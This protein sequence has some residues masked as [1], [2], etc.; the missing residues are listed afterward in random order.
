MPQ[1]KFRAIVIGGGPIGL[2]I[3]NGLD[4]A[5]IDFLV[6]ERN[7]NIISKSGACIMAWPHTTRIFDQ[8]GLTAACQGRYLPLQSKS[9]AHLDGRPI[10]ANPI[11]EYLN[12]NHGYPCMNFPRPSLTQTLFEGLGTNQAKVRTGAGIEG[13]E[14][15]DNGV[16][17]RLTDGSFEDGSIVIG[18]D[19]VHS[20]TRAIM[21]KLAEEAG[22]DFVKEEDPIVSNYQILYGRAKYVPG[23]KVGQFFET[24]GTHRSSQISAD[25]NRMHFGIYRKLPNPTTEAKEYSE[26]EVA[27]FAEAFSDVMVMPNLSFTELYKNCEWTKLANQQEGVLKHWYYNRIVLAGDSTVQMTAAMGMGLNNGIQSAVFLVNKLQEL[28]SKDS[29]PDTAALGCAF[30][31]YQNTRRE[32]SQVITGHA[33]RLIRNNTWDTYL[34][35]F[36]H[37]YVVPWM[38]TEEKLIATVGNHLLSKMHKFDFIDIEFKSGKI[39]WAIA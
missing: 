32:E 3:A 29:N 39:P 11:F 16:R 19:G 37:E 10:R 14:M 13:I 2:M 7:P 20:K 34:G 18:A 26:D 6:I 4:R 36:M 27:E 25:K 23:V 5:G 31:E 35:W 9:V 28:L 1:S 22:K 30:E 8:L 38:M 24:H 21:H 33:A 15:T 17:V 12:D